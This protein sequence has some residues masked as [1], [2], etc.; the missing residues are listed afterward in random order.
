MNNISGELYRRIQLGNSEGR[1]NVR[2]TLDLTTNVAVVTQKIQELEGG[3]VSFG[4]VIWCSIERAK[5]TELSQLCGI[6]I[7][8]NPND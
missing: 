3:F 5:I 7:D 4:S 1:I 6:Y 8:C 2:I